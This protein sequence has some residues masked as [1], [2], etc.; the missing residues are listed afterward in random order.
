[1]W[2]FNNKFFALA[3]IV[4]SKS[5]S[6]W[7]VNVIIKR[8]QYIAADYVNRCNTF[9]QRA[10]TLQL[11]PSREWGCSGVHYRKPR[12]MSALVWPMSYLWWRFFKATPSIFATPVGRGTGDKTSLDTGCFR[13][14]GCQLL[15]SYL[16]CSWIYIFRWNLC[17][18]RTCT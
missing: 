5:P 10:D 17:T 14:R 7:A 1:M 16:S 9:I 12:V 13:T 11:G 15:V 2:N 18:L 6:F 4:F 3:N 8:L